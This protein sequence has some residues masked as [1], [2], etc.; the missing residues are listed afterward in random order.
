MEGAA[1]STATT[2]TQA[3]SGHGSSATPTPAAASPTTLGSS[4]PWRSES[5]PPTRL[6]AA[7]NP[8]ATRNVPAI[9]A[10][11][12][13]RPAGPRGGGDPSGADN[14]A[15]KDTNHT[16]TPPPRPPRAP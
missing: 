12:P 16:P 10:A 5:R 2:S 9:A 11:P 8:A 7:S 13:P 14:Q 6:S 1:T 15:P 4:R 3:V